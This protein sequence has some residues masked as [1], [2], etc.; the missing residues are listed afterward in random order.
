MKDRS[1]SLF[2]PC[3]QWTTLAFV[4]LGTIFATCTLSFSWSC[5]T[6]SFGLT[7]KQELTFRFSKNMHL[8]C[9]H[10]S[11]S[12][13]QT[14]HRPF[15]GRQWEIELAL[16]ANKHNPIQKKNLLI[17][18]PLLLLNTLTIKPCHTPLED[19]LNLASLT[20]EWLR[21]GRGHPSLQLQCLLLQVVGRDPAGLPWLRQWHQPPVWPGRV[22]QLWDEGRN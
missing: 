9:W 17:S 20:V 15:P 16:F 2:I 5:G 6:G 18:S 1:L 14:T 12:Q 4:N 19:P 7:K 10:F 3:L 21:S 13:G 8:I 11:F 22:H